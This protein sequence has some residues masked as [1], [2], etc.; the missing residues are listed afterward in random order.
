MPN[1]Q[2]TLR[3]GTTFNFFGQMGPSRQL[4]EVA[5]RETTRAQ[6]AHVHGIAVEATQRWLRLAA[7]LERVAVR[8]GRVERL[9]L[10]LSILEARHQLGEVAGVEVAQLNLEHTTTTAQLELAESDAAALDNAVAEL[11]GQ[12]FL[13]PEIGDLDSILEASK[14]PPAPVLEADA[15]A[16]GAPVQIA[17]AAA[18]LEA[19]RSEVAAATAWGRPA[20]EAEWEHF[21]EVDGV[22]SFDAWGFRFSLPLPFG[23]IPARQKAAARERSANALAVREAVLQESLARARGLAALADGATQR[24]EILKP[25]VVELHQIERSLSAQY[26]LGTITYLEYVYGTTR[27]DDVLLEAIEARTRLAT[28]RLELALLLN[29]PDVFPIFTLETEEAS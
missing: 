6:A 11:C 10:A 25:L 3:F 20:I 13:R 22:E 1:A 7:A 2:D 14:T 23:S 8:R 26:R 4:R 15:I 17:T 19:A 29:D 28:A 9:E 5:E 18:E 16:A 27:H 12:A 21:P 24:L